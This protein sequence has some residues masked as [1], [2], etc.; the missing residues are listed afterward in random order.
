MRKIPAYWQLNHKSHYHQS[1]G[2]M[3]RQEKAKRQRRQK[4]Q[5]RVMLILLLIFVSIFLTSRLGGSYIQVSRA[6]KIIEQPIVI[7]EDKMIFVSDLGSQW[8]YTRA[9]R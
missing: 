2:S 5:R 3:L 4:N 1:V 8:P 7:V 6:P 9:G